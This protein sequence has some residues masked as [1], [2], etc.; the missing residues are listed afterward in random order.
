M[1][2]PSGDVDQNSLQYHRGQLLLSLNGGLVAL[3]P[4]GNTLRPAVPDEL[5]ADSVRKENL[6]I[7]KQLDLAAQQI[8]EKSGGR[9]AIAWGPSA[10]E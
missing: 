8:A 3:D 9:N 1:L 6:G 2:L 10:V 5:A 7:H 4:A